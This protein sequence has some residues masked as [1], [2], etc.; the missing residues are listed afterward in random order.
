MILIGQHIR[1]RNADAPMVIPFHER[2]RHDSGLSGGLSMAGYDIHLKQDVVLGG[3]LNPFRSS[4]KIASSVERFDIPDNILVEV[5]DK[6]T[7]ARQG[8]SVFNTV[9]EPGWAGFL[10]L[11]L[12]NQHPWRT[13]RIKAG[14]PIAQLLFYNLS[15]MAEPYR[16]K[17]NNQADHPV[18]AILE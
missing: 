8:L 7:W 14:T 18:E 15:G 5:K 13:I 4:F 11:E 2:T 10:T 9:I 16:G 17:Y 12:K 1:E 3:A 6:S